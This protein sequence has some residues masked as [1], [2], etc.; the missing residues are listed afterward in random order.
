MRDQVFISLPALVRYTYFRGVASF[1]KKEKP[2]FSVVVPCY[3]NP[4]FLVNTAQSIAVQSVA[5]VSIV[6]VNDGKFK[7]TADAIASCVAMLGEDR[8]VVIDQENRGVAAARNAGIDAAV[9]NWVIPLDYDDVIAPRYIERC[10]DIVCGAKDVEFIYPHSLKTNSSDEYWIPRSGN[11]RR[12]LDRCLYPAFSAFSK[13]LWRRVGGYEVCH[14]LGMDDW[15]FFIK[16]VMSGAPCC[17][18]PFFMGTWRGH[19]LNETHAARRNWQC[20]RAMIVTLSHE[21]RD[22][23][24]VLTALEV[25]AGMADE[26][27]ARVQDK[28]R[29]F[30]EH[31]Y[32]HM[33][34]ALAQ[35]RRGEIDIAAA[36]ARKAESLAPSNWIMG[37]VAG[38]VRSR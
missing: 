4:E 6:F 5:P 13:E 29:L 30:P 17:R 14:P 37:H 22:R 23:N 36:F 21:W 3:N 10:S 2:S 20:G 32:P 1:A 26:V 35:L 25:I 38:L 28:V 31:P 15:D 11:P 9:G 12:I 33:W 24:E 7:V 18:L 27:M 16:I 8:C 34:L 19:A